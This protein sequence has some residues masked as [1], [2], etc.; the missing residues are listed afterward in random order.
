MTGFDKGY[1][2]ATID[3][4]EM[5]YEWAKKMLKLRKEATGLDQKFTEGYQA[6]I[7]KEEE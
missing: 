3:I 6:R 2:R 1:W 5:G 7:E 4:M